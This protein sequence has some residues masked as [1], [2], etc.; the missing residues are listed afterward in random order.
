MA[1]PHPAVL[2]ALEQVV[3]D[4]V[5]GGGFEPEPGPQLGGLDVSAVSRLLDPCP[6]RV[7][8]TSPAV[9]VVEGVAERAERLLPAGRGDVEAPPG[10]QVASGGEDMDV[11]TAVLLP[12]EHRRPSVAVGFEPGPGRL[13]EGVQKRIDLFVGGLVLRCPRDHAGGV[14]VIEGKRVGHGGHLIRSPA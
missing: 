8:R 13:L 7:V 12:V 4:Q 6:R 9:L 3:P 14:L 5:S 11:G 10:L 1:I 2:D